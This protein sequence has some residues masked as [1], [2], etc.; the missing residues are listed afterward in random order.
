MA[1]MGLRLTIT[2][3]ASPG[4]RAAAARA[5]AV[6]TAVGFVLTML[7]IVAAGNA[8]EQWFFVLL[9]WVA[10]VYLP[11]RILLEAAHTF[12]PALRRALAAQASEQP[13]RHATRADVELMVEQLFERAVVMPRIA[14]PVHADKA[15]AGAVALLVQAGDETGWRRATRGC[16]GAVDRWVTWLGQ[17]AAQE[18]ASIQARW[19]EVRALAALAAMTRVLLAAEKDRGGQ[20]WG[21]GDASVP[22][23]AEFL[24]TCL[25]YCDD[26][27]LQVEVAP[28]SWPPLGLPL[29]QE[30]ADELRST[31]RTF[32]ETTPPA[33]EARAAFTAL[34]LRVSCPPAQP[35]AS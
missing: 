16:L 34:L 18:G 20:P 8:A 10:L 5:L 29:P 4:T 9:V 23:T 35:T 17:W 6:L 28:W 3:L 25:D 1:L 24:D 27:A 14:T 7:I 21:E 30:S 32:V 12:A 26:L 15:K 11:L 13:G 2:K 19:G 33:L 31:W 22:D